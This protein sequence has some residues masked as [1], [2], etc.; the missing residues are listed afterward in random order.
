MINKV[1]PQAYS[2]INKILGM[3]YE[4]LPHYCIVL[5]RWSLLRPF[6][7]YCAPPNLD[8]STWICRFNFAQ[9]PIFSGLRFF[10]ESEILDSG[11][12]AWSP[13]RGTCA[14][15]F[16][17]LKKIHRPS[18]WLSVAAWIRNLSVSKVYVF[19]T[20]IRNYF[21]RSLFPNPHL[22]GC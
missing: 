11:P 14:Q 21:Y 12:R 1:P 15:D 6:Q 3:S 10:N 5:I 7:I 13:S 8:I 19:E 4:I 16:Y 17:V 9:R 2:S 18:L 20:I 22:Y